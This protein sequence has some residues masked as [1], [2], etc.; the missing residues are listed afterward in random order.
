MGLYRNRSPARRKAT[1][2]WVKRPVSSPSPSPW[3]FAVPPDEPLPDGLVVVVVVKRDCPTCRLVAPVLGE[4][5]RRPPLTV[6]YQDDPVFPTEVSGVV[7]DSALAVS[8]RLDLGHRPD[9]AAGRTR[10]RGGPPRRLAAR[11]VGGADRDRGGSGL[12]CR[13]T[14][15]AAA[16]G[17]WIR[18][19]AE[20]LAIPLRR[21]RAALPAGLERVDPHGCAVGA[22]LGP[23]G[24]HLT[25]VEPHSQDG[26]RALGPRLVHHPL[27]D[28]VAALD[29]CGGHP[30][31]LATDQRLELGAELGADV[32]GPHGQAENL[33][34]HLGDGVPRQVVHRRDQHDVSSGSFGQRT[35]GAPSSHVQ[36]G[37]Y[38]RVL[39]APALPVPRRARPATGSP[40]RSGHRPP[41]SRVTS[42]SGRVV[43]SRSVCRRTGTPIVQARAGGSILMR[44]MPSE[45]PFTSQRPRQP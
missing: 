24:T 30:P 20:E 27:H 31:E 11:A 25:G 7:D 9:P 18:G 13:S 10:C 45:D 38:G 12:T 41:L 26:V 37:R 36:A 44:T 15:R 42:S 39:S 1:T 5:A 19:A 43:L 21:Q 40:V 23:V 8:H 32:A 6:Y 2:R 34:E 17:R 22:D 14:G 29:Q 4:L 28:L 16:P 33:T 3:Y 35:A